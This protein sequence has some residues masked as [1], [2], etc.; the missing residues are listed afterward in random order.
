MKIEHILSEEVYEVLENSSN[1]WIKSLRQNLEIFSQRRSD[2]DH[3]WLF[4]SDVAL[5]Q[6]I[7]KLKRDKNYIKNINSVV[8]MDISESIKAI[9]SLFFNRSEA[10]MI[11]SLESLNRE[12]FLSTSILCR[13][14]LELCMWHLRHSIAFEKTLV[15][16]GKELSDGKSDTKLHIVHNEELANKIVKLIFGSKL[17]DTDLENRQLN[18]FKVIPLVAEGQKKFAEN[19]IDLEKKYDFFSEFVHPN[20]CGNSVF[21]DWDLGAKNKRPAT[22]QTLLVSKKQNDEK[23]EKVL[24]NVAETISW[25]VAAILH[26]SEKYDAAVKSIEKIFFK[27]THLKLVKSEKSRRRKKNA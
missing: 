4:L 20:V 22:P 2:L 21:V 6:T 26:S 7:S 8:W 16:L 25:A 5:L 19:K 23:D 17:K 14:L 13:S 1:I 27:K 15:N 3:K 10:L 24:E 18:V 9:K 12:D 11:S